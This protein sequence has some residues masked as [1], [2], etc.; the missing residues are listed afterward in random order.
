RPRIRPHVEAMRRVIAGALG[1]DTG[2]V[3]I[4]GKT[5]EGLDAIGRGEALA[6]WAVA[7]LTR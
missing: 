3:S 1:I 6:A 4:K 7:L 2:Q 5:N